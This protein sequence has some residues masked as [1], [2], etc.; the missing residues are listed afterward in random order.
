[1]AIPSEQISRIL[2]K[3]I[4]IGLILLTLIVFWPVH[5]ADF[6]IMTTRSL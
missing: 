2:P 5:P 4:P 1:M 6:S 3:L